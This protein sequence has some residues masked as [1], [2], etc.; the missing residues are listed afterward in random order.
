MR[1]GGLSTNLGK[2]QIILD[3]FNAM[4]NPMIKIPEMLKGFLQVK[5][6]TGNSKP[7]IMAGSIIEVDGILYSIAS[8]TE[9]YNDPFETGDCYIIAIAS[10]GSLSFQLTQYWSVQTGSISWNQDKQGWY[11]PGYSGGRVIGKVFY[12]GTG[13]SYP[14]GSRLPVSDFESMHV[15]RIYPVEESSETY[16]GDAEIYAITPRAGSVYLSPGRYRYEI[17]SADS[18]NVYDDNGSIYTEYGYMSVGNAGTEATGVFNF[19]GGRLAYWVGQKGGDAGRGDS[20]RENPRR[21]GG[22]GEGGSSRVGWIEVLGGDRTLRKDVAD[23]TAA[24]QHGERA[25]GWRGGRGGDGIVYL[26][27]DSNGGAP[28]A[29][30]GGA[31]VRLYR[32]W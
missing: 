7:K 2:N 23:Q 17:R 21:D 11:H 29:A 5:Y 20:G 25:R 6:T 24:S 31:Y 1:V 16:K 28:G 13:S 15:V 32:I 26:Y 30:S 10:N 19:P 3:S 18:G 4:N 9:I 27:P 8:Q 14:Y 22:A 12:R